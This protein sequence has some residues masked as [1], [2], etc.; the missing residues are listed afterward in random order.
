MYLGFSQKA[1]VYFLDEPF[2]FLDDKTRSALSNLLLNIDKKV[3][4]IDHPDYELSS[5]N[6][7]TLIDI[8]GCLE[9]RD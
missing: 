4:I 6:V 7:A 1:D 2:Q 9:L 3:C 8:G 5:Y